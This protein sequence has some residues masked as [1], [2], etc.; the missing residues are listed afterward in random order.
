VL[1]DGVGGRPRGHAGSS[2]RT[3]LTGGVAHRR[4]QVDTS[5]AREP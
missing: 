4:P 3:S 2:D 5:R 1:V